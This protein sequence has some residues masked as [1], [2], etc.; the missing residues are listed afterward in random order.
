[1]AKPAD[2]GGASASPV[3]VPPQAEPPQAEPKVTPA[4]TSPKSEAKQPRRFVVCRSGWLAR[5][6]GNVPSTTED[7]I[8]R[9]GFDPD[10]CVKQGLIKPV[11]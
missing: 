8:R 9:R 1:M 10:A 3:S 2:L 6:F 4:A 11:T 5:H 7:L